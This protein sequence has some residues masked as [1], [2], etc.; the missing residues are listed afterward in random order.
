MYGCKMNE[1][2]PEGVGERER[3]RVPALPCGLYDV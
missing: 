2:K 3:E 1:F